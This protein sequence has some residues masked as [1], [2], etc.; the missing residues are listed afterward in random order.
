MQ[1]VS[2]SEERAEF[3]A[4]YVFLAIIILTGTAFR[5][6]FIGYRA[7][8]ICEL[9]SVSYATLSLKRAVCYFAVGQ[10]NTSLLRSP[11]LLGQASWRF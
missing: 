2:L 1:R 9:Y 7:F 8:W 6:Y 5:A 10:P 3:K 4:W 11:S